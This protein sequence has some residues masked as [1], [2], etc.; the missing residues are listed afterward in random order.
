VMSCK[1]PMGLAT[2]NSVATAYPS[3]SR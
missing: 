2:M 3:A 1:F